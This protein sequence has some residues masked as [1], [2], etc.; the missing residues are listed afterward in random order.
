ME[1]YFV[2]SSQAN[3]LN[4]LV[5]LISAG[6]SPFLGIL[7]D[8]TGFNLMWCKFE[9]QLISGFI[10]ASCHHKGVMTSNLFVSM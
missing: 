8:K 6:A 7:V 5:Y 9:D 4:S 1:K 3:I 2:N 10:K